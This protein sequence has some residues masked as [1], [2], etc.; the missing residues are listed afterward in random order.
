MTGRSRESVACFGIVQ[1]VDCKFELLDGALAAAALASMG[2]MC[3]GVFAQTDAHY[4]AVDAYLLRRETVRRAPGL[5]IGRAARADE[6]P[7]PPTVEWLYYSRPRRAAP[8]VNV[9]TSLRE[10]AARARF[11]T[12]PRAL[13]VIVQKERA[14]WRLPSGHR[15]HLDEVVTL[16][17]FVELEARVPPRGGVRARVKAVE[18]LRGALR[19][20]L[21]ECLSAGYADLLA[22]EQETGLLGRSEAVVSLT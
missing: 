11:G 10:E 20:A 12:R 19:P 8:R 5:E 18:N 4:R 7:G 16:G 3:E 6:T 14:T 21:G 9:G 22:L 17:R 2:A 1:T 13:W 15:V